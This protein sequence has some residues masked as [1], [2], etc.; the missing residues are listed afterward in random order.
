MATNTTKKRS[1]IIGGKEYTMPQ[2]MSTMA[3][4]HYL[5]VRDAVMDTEA[6]QALYTRQ[7]FIDM[8]D[9]IVELYGNQFTQEDMLDAENGL[10]PD[11]IVMEF[12][13][14][15]VAVGEKVDKRVEKF[16]ENFTNGKSCRN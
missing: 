4:L 12:A 2:K 9:V 3:Y 7:Q 6:K 10:T 8:M 14:M 11:E 5:E 15:D 16:K 1:I 13:P